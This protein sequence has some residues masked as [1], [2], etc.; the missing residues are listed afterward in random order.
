MKRNLSIFLGILFAIVTLSNGQFEKAM[1]GNIPV[2]FSSSTPEE[3]QAVINQLSRIGEA[4]GD[5]WEPYY[6]SA[7]GYIRMSGMFERGEDKDKYLNLAKAEVEKG[8]AIDPSNSE[9]E[10]LKGY[11]IMMQ[12]TVDPQSRGMMYSG[13]A[14]ESFHKAIKMDP[15]NPRAHYLL[16]RMEYGT[17]QFM[18]GANEQACGSLLKARKLFMKNE[19]PDRSFSPTWGKESTEAAIKE[20]CEGGE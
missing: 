8:Q 10:A 7:Y 4:E 12:L 6:Y 20:I 18:G 19:E 2:V 9:L 13:R 15:D 14:F 11:H 16:G 1:G 17:A 3:L 5:R